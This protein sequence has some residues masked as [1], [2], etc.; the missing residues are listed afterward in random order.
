MK[1]D[2]IKSL[3]GGTRDGK[4]IDIFLKSLECLNSAI[5]EKMLVN[6]KGPEQDFKKD[7]IT[8]SLDKLKVE[9]DLDLNYISDEDFMSNVESSD[10]ILLPYRRVLKGNSGP[11]TEGV[12]R[13]KCII[14]PNEGTIGF[15]IN[16]YKL[17][18]TFESENPRSLANALETYFENE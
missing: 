6:I 12:A 10:V 4:G 1:E 5:K 9:Y 3:L 14:G 18:Y 2:V 16:K 17:G 15:L 13:E 8:N 11:M 7:Y